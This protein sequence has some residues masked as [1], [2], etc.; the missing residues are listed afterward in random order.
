MYKEWLEPDKL[1]LLESWAR[2]GLSNTQLA[3]KIGIKEN[4][5]YVWMSQHVK[6]KEALKKGK[7]VADFEVE[8]ALFKNA[9]GYYQKINKVHKIKTIKVVE[10]KRLETEELV[11]KEEE[12]F[13]QPN[14][15][16]QIFWLKNRKSDAWKNNP[17]PN[18]NEQSIQILTQ[19]LEE[20]KKN[21]K[22]Q[23]D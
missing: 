10:G 3:E 23:G 16:A 18:E 6:I 21:A 11:E 20:T 5:L 8:N 15:A 17:V 2:S 12:V 22:K 9:T 19:I 4:T 7:E 1:F 13:F 14:T